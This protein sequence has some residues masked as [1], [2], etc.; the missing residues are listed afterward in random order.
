MMRST[1]LLLLASAA[2]AEKHRNVTFWYTP[3]A[4]GG[5]DIDTLVSLMS[6]HSNTVGSVILECKHSLNSTHPLG[7]NC[8]EPF[9]EL[10][11]TCKPWA[12]T[13]LKTAEGLTAAGIRVELLI[14]GPDGAGTG[15]STNWTPSAFEAANASTFA[16]TMVEVAK[17]YNATGINMDLE[18]DQG[19]GPTLLPGPYAA[20][21][22]TV[23]PILNAGGLRLTADVAA[24]CKMTS[25]YALLAPAVDR[26]LNMEQ[27]NADSME[28][29]LKGDAYGGYYEQFVAAAPVDKCA[30]GLGIWGAKCAKNASG[31]PQ[32]CWSTLEE[33]GAPRIDRMIADNVPEIALF[34][35]MWIGGAHQPAAWWWPVLDK[36]AAS[37]LA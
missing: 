34:R 35:L 14:G 32:P 21:L 10:P 31:A 16:A 26:L 12:S 11:A 25:D 15:P 24:W 33:S 23:K 1:T 13:C 27:Y 22:K 17:R 5:G 19:G 28:G 6:N 30:P 9:D 37:P 36:F 8:A 7:V 3:A 20:Y 2:Y 29:W 18:P 4:Y